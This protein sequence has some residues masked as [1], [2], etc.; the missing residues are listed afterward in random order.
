LSFGVVVGI[1]CQ[2]AVSVRLSLTAPVSGL[3]TGED[4]YSVV[5]D[6]SGNK[7]EAKELVSASKRV[8]DIG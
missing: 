1:A 5:Y 6:G 4:G 8:V 7:P 3:E 2:R